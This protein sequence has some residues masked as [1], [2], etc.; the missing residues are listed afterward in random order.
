MNEVPVNGGPTKKLFTPIRIPG[1]EVSCVAP[2]PFGPGFSLG[3]DNGEVKFTDEA[4]VILGEMKGS[5][6]GEAINGIASFGNSIAVSSRQEV[7]LGT[8]APGDSRRIAKFRVPH[9]AHGISA[10]PSG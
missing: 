4:G 10:T 5:P 1:V 8:W 7:M 6:S 2:N 9:G 3:T